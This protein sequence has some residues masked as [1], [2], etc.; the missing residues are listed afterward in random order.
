MNL[1]RYKPSGKISTS[2]YLFF[3]LF[4]VISIPILSIVYIYLTY[5][6]PFIY[7]NF[8]I[9]L[10]CG[11]A[12][13]FVATLAATY[14]KAR[15]AVV[16]GILTFVAV[17]ILKYV[18]WAVYI[19]LIISEFFGSSMTMGERFMETLFLLVNPAYI[20]D[21]AS[22]INEIGVWSLAGADVTGAFLFAV[23]VI[24]FIILAVAAVFVA[25]VQPGQ[26]FSE[27][28]NAW[29]DEAP[30]K[31]EADMP[32]DISTVINALDNGNAVD[33]VQC[34]LAG[35][36][37]DSNFMRLTFFKPPE[38]S[39]SL[40][41]YYVDI[42]HIIIAGTKKKPTTQANKLAAFVAITPETARSVIAQATTASSTD[43]PNNE[44]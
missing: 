4:M 23:W 25:R 2:F 24:E 9:T 36:T 41:P 26:P 18:Q 22:I 12:L 31:I 1:T 20:I 8:F 11:A 10:G 44:Q 30:E 42:E 6:I 3:V 16:A 43:I 7:I 39:S 38:N 34:A 32:E 14:G 37:N 28:A 40:E 29:Y 15:N 33:F 19:P 5:Y 13:G 21:S 27:E 17:C 35:K